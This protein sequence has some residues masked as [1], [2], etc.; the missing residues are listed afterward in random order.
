MSIFDSIK[1]K[2]KKHDTS[3]LTGVGLVDGLVVGG[4]LWYKTGAKVNDLIKEKEQEKGS[5]L[6]FKE[7]VKCSWKM[8][9]IP[10]ANTVL[11]A[12]A[13]I[14]SDKI[15]AKRYASLGIAYS[16]TE[17]TLQKYQEKVVQEVGE[18]KA[19]E[20]KSSAVSEVAKDNMK[21][22]EIIDT[23]HGTVPIFETTSCR[24][25][26][27]NWDKVDNAVLKANEVATLGDGK[28]S[29]SYLYRELGIPTSGFSDKNGWDINRSGKIRIS[30]TCMLDDKDR[31]CGVIDYY[32]LPYEI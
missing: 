25:L 21:T 12:T 7:K 32:D 24:T 20:I 2:I 11:S 27:T 23:G 10:A 19:T 1:D 26:L 13:I 5:A 16:L 18:K 14:L 9:L 30:H 28:V 22:A 4:Y 15:S 17:A 6:T 31:P 8:F 29:L 3:I